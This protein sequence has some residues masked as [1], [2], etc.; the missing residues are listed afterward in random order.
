MWPLASSAKAS[1]TS[2]RG[3]SRRSGSQ[4]RRPRSGPP[5]GRGRPR[6]R[7]RALPSALIPYFSTASK[8]TMVSTRS[9]EMPSSFSGQF[10][11]VVAVRVDERV[12]RVRR[13]GPD[14]V[15]HAVPVGHGY[16]AVGA[17]PVVVPLPRQAHHVGA[18][19]LRQL[20][21]DRADAAR[22]A[23]HHHGVAAAGA[24][25]RAPPPTP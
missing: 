25:P 11:V 23:G 22:R 10:D 13:R 9:A 4:V 18:V 16:D 17:Q 8:R 2:A 15:R 3:R 6:W 7:R 24:R 21:R 1:L 20:H 14:P 5:A 12:R 19:A